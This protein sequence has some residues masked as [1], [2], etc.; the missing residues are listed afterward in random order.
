MFFQEKNTGSIPYKQINNLQFR[1][2][3]QQAA[4][5]FH[6]HHAPRKAHLYQFCIKMLL[7]H[8]V[9]NY[10]TSKLSAKWN[11]RRIHNLSVTVHCENETC[12]GG[13]GLLHLS[14]TERLLQLVTASTGTDISFEWRHGPQLI[15]FYPSFLSAVILSS[16]RAKA[17]S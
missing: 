14:N 5:H 15:S 12:K 1:I 4:K 3:T 7:M 17:F 10:A 16:V 8:P 9:Y 11:D 2:L 13:G 6:W